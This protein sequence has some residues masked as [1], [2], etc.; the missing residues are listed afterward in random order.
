MNV[1]KLTDVI[2]EDTLRVLLQGFY[3]KTRIPVSIYVDSGNEQFIYNE[4]D[5][6]PFCREKIKPDNLNGCSKR[7][8]DLAKKVLQSTDMAALQELRKCKF[9][10]CHW[11]EVI[12]HKATE[13]PVAVM[14]FGGVVTNEEHLGRFAPEYRQFL[15]MKPQEFEEA[16]KQ[17]QNYIGDLENYYNAH[18]QMMNYAEDKTLLTTYRSLS[19]ESPTFIEFIHRDLDQ[20]FDNI[21]RFLNSW[22]GSRLSALCILDPQE[23]REDTSNDILVVRRMVGLKELEESA[24]EQLD[25]PEILNLEESFLGQAIKKKAP[26]YKKDV[27]P[28]EFVWEKGVRTLGAKKALAL[29]LILSPGNQALGGLICFPQRDIWPAEFPMFDNFARKIAVTVHLAI[30]N[31]LYRRNQIFRDGLMSVSTEIGDE[32]YKD[33]AGLIRETL[34]A[35]AASIFI[36]D[37]STDQLK[38]VGTTDDSPKAKQKLG[39]NV[40]KLGEG[41]TGSIAA[42]T[43]V[44]PYGEI[45]YDL[46]ANPRRSDKFEEKVK[47]TRS[48]K[49]SLIA[50][51]ILSPQGEVL[52]VVRCVDVRRERGAVFN[53]FNH[54]YLEGLQ[55]WAGIIGIIYTM[56]QKMHLNHKY[57][58][59]FMHEFGSSL[60]GLINNMELVPEYLAIREEAAAHKKVQ[61]AIIIGKIM[62][63]YSDDIL[64]G[65]LIATEGEF[66]V[67]FLKEEFCWLETDFLMPMKNS[68]QNWALNER[69]IGI[70]Y[71][72]LNV[73]LKVDKKRI[74]QV[75][76]NLLSNAIKYSYDPKDRKVS[77]KMLADIKMVSYF[78][79]Y[80]WFYVD[81]INQG[82]GI[83]EDEKEVIFNLYRKGRNAGS[84]SPGGLGLGLFICRE[85][86]K[87]HGGRIFVKC[88][89]NPTIITIGFPKYRL[90]PQTRRF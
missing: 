48:G 26:V 43:D 81:F 3:L 9:G 60:G 29:P 6:N 39:K 52:G 76:T 23:P 15:R 34:Q 73:E 30:R 67:G 77:K 59:T 64:L 65:S 84:Q 11:A 69:G 50:T 80:D 16:K 56:K 38:L 82:I 35:A 44:K 10:L 2:T 58:L 19:S 54:F 5:S 36:L 88:N 25:L 27:D 12:E 14:S 55:F 33:M 83:H 90:G 71:D 31:E 62:S 86:M 61:D 87:R 21:L 79:D 40:Y 46:Y 20:T 32:L 85:V 8:L 24:G 13:Q 17:F 57:I 18:V 28:V 51:Q 41:I 4:S 74:I 49:H 42:R 1:P 63:Q 22:T 7:N 37:R 47:E 78:G 45:V 66:K 89:R 72:P 70:R 75:F 68:F 53:C